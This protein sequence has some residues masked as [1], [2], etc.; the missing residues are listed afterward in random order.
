MREPETLAEFLRRRLGGEMDWERAMALADEWNAMRRLGIK[1]DR[2]VR[3]GGPED[4]EGDRCTA[5][6]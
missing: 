5:T 6:T 4:R 3:A 1:W 2:R